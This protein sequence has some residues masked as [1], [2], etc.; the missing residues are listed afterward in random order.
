MMLENINKLKQ[1]IDLIEMISFILNT[2][3]KAGN[4]PSK[5][6]NIT[7]EQI[8]TNLLET[9]SQESRITQEVV[10]EKDIVREKITTTITPEVAETKASI[11]IKEERVQPPITP[12]ADEFVKEL[13]SSLAQRIQMAPPPNKN[14]SPSRIG[15]TRELTMQDE[16][17]NV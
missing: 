13:S 6:L 4:I 11:N 8:K 2:E 1:S 7:L 14:A 16:N 17:K 9:I 3:N 12:D 15:R 5:G 10:R